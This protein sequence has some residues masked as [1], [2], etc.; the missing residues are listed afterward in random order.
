MKVEEA[1]KRVTG[2]WYVRNDEIFIEI[3]QFPKARP[4]TLPLVTFKYIS[5]NKIE[6]P[7]NGQMN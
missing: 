6:W 7:Q 4:Y 3:K 2:N 5:E 1:N